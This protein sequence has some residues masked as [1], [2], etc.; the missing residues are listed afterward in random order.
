MRILL[1]DVA[2][3]ELRIHGEEYRHER[4]RAA[5]DV[6]VEIVRDERVG[7]FRLEHGRGIV[8][9][10]VQPGPSGGDRLE[11]NNDHVWRARRHDFGAEPSRDLP[12]QRRG[13]RRARADPIK[14]VEIRR[15]EFIGQM[16]C[17]I[18][19]QPPRGNENPRRVFS[20][21]AILPRRPGC[22]ESIGP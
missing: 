15:G 5:A 13:R 16:Q 12:D 21:T 8:R 3:T 11:D 17:S 14:V 18:A 22:G 4:I 7:R 20:N 6:R 19:A 9:P 1:R 2:E 10:A